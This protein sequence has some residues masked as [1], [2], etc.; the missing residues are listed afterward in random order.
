MNKLCHKN[1]KSR[2]CRS[3]V[4]VAAVITQFCKT[5]QHVSM[6]TDHSSVKTEVGGYTYVHMVGNIGVG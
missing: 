4:V 3:F 1:S 2:A 5:R 6:E